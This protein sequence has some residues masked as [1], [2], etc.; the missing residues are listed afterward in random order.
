MNLLNQMRGMTDSIWRDESNRDERFQRVFMAAGWQAW[1]RLARRPLTTKLFNKYR[2]RAYPD[3]TVSSAAF[4]SRIP[5]SRHIEFFRTQISGGT[6]I[7]VGANV[8]LVSMLLADKIE[9]ALL[10]EPN[11]IA[12][13]RARENVRLNRLAYEVHEL[14]LSDQNGTV[15]FE[16]VGGA[17]PYNRAVVGFTTTAPTITVLRSTLDD[18]L[19]IHA[20][21]PTPITAIKIDVEGHENSVLRGMRSVLRT[22]RPRTIMFEYLQRTNLKETFE[23][24][25]ECSYRV[26]FLTKSGKTQWATVD[27]EPLQDLF[28]CPEELGQ[29]LAQAS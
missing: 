27:V 8:G 25:S 26:M 21:L 7:D 13:A 10:F 12:A 5:N 14:A 28:A 4:Y 20:P 17:N 22:H 9:H 1:K 19:A 15:T 24:F 6:L 11:P 29:E 3:C 16:N 18:F 2:F 23:I